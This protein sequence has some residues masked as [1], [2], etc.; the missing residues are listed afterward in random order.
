MASVD[1]IEPDSR[2]RY[3][4]IH[5]HLKTAIALGNIAPGLVLLEG[6]VARIFGTSRV[7]VRKAF[8]MLHAGGL[9]HT[10]DGRGYLV[11]HPDG[12]VPEPLR[13]PLSED[14]LG[15]DRPPEPLDIPSNSERIYNA[16]EGVISL[17][18]V[19]G[20][21][22][23]DESDAAEAFGVSRGTVREAL[24]RLRDR[25]LV[26]KAA[27]SHWLC[28][29]LTARAV[30]E[31]YELRVLLEPAALLASAPSLSR[32]QLEAALVE[33]ERAIAL[34]DSVDAAALYRIETTLHD[35]LL[36]F[37]RNRKLRAAIG[38]AH[39]PLIVNHAFYDAFNLHPEAGMLSEHREV[40]RLLLKGN[41]QAAADALTQHLRAGQK[42]TLQRLKVLAVLPDPD[43]PAYMQ[44]IA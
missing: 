6:P 29:P 37:S 21:F 36:S 17:G 13:A 31:D 14:A 7:P 10:F 2:L 22:R 15:F 43:L 4:L 34:P 20:H 27:Y 19:F 28:G 23:I 25:G 30:A 42:R 24:N 38:H 40:V 39:M 33:I 44:R 5:D 35:S 1:S 32:A 41:A 18:I 9:L 12:G 16:L 3:R 8:E 26:E 11:A